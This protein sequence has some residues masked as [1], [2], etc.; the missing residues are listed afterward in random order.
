MNLPGPSQFGCCLKYQRERLDEVRAGPESGESRTGYRRSSRLSTSPGS[1]TFM[2]SLDNDPHR[3]QEKWILSQRT[4]VKRL[5]SGSRSLTK[6]KEIL[7]LIDSQQSNPASQSARILTRSM[8]RKLVSVENISVGPAAKKCKTDRFPATIGIDRQLRGNTS[9]RSSKGKEGGKGPEKP[10]LNR[11]DK[12]ESVIN[13][14]AWKEER[15]ER[16]TTFS[17]TICNK[18]EVTL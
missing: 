2:K 13:F 17:A 18:D 7:S 16:D 3:L 10:N 6:S 11:S 4:P 15:K 5:N 8:K 9:S 12:D 1:S 14:D